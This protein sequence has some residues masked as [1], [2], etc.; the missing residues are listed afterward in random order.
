[1]ESNYPPG[2]I[3]TFD[4]I[5]NDDECDFIIKTIDKYA[6]IDREV[7][8]PKRNVIADSINSNEI[9]NSKVKDLIFEKVLS[10]CKTFKNNYNIKISG[11]E[12]PTLRRIKGPTQIHKDGI[13]VRGERTISELRNM[14]IIIALNDDYEGGEFCFP[15]QGCTIKLKKGQAVAFPPYWT[16][17]HYTNEL[18]DNTFRY[19]VNFWTYEQI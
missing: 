10:I 1:M 13:L 9:P 15:E 3:F 7:Y 11:L 6:V 18:R 5:F 2:C 8:G 17:P 16:H 4:D 14:A 19:T 12:S